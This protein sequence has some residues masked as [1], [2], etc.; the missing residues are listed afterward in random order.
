MSAEDKNPHVD[1]RRRMKDRF[2]ENGLDNFPDVNVLELLLF[3]SVSRKDTNPLAH[4]LLERFGSLKAVLEASEDEL[5]S[6]PGIGKESARLLRLVPAVSKRYISSLAEPSS[7][8]TPITTPSAAADALRATFLYERNE[9]VVALFLDAQ[10][11]K[12]DI[13][14]IGEGTVN[15]SEIRTRILVEK[16]LGSHCSSVIL[17]HNHPGGTLSPSREDRE[18]TA[19]LRQALSMVDITLSDHL[20]FADNEYVSLRELGLF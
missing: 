17:A 11:K 7:K 15:A 5:C 3:Y 20:I 1:H 8:K 10:G 14:P 16:A 13:Q 18:T 6:V 4:A 9:I 12:L 2:S 19:A